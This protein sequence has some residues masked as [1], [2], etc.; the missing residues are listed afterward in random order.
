MPTEY[1]FKHWAK[2][3]DIYGPISSVTVLGQPIVLLNSLE[4]CVDL[5]DKRSSVYSGRP[6][7]HFAGT[8]IKWDL[9]MI[10]SPYG[11]RFRAMRKLVARQIGS[12]AAVAKPAIRA[13]QEREIRHFLARVCEQPDDLLHELR[14]TTAAVFMRL[15]HGYIISKDAN[16]PD[17]LLK[18]IDTAAEE[19]YVATRPGAW[20]VDTF[21]FLRHIPDWFPGAGFKHVAKEFL[22]TN[23]EQVEIPLAYVKSEIR[24]K[25]APSS[26]TADA[27]EGGQFDDSVIMCAAGSLFAGGTDTVVATMGTFILLM[28]RHPEIQQK[29]QAELDAL[30]GGRRL[31]TLD[32]KENLPYLTAVHK[33]VLRW[34]IIGPMGI[35]HST[36]ADDYYKGYFIPKGTIV[37]SNLW[38][39]SQDTAH[40]AEP[41]IFNPE[42]FLGPTPELDPHKYAFGFGR[43]MC[44]GMDLSDANVFLFMAL[45]LSVLEFGKGKGEVEG[46]PEPL[47]HSGTV[48]HPKPYKYSV[49]PRSEEAVRLIQAANDEIPP[50]ESDAPKVK[51]I[52]VP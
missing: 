11:E 22:K 19:F 14:L 50:R 4:G 9:Q 31:P 10:L 13:A 40:H 26:F 52:L 6:T 47:F 7:M 43:R 18:L 1:E 32:D 36:T 46:G 33:E 24:A 25:R 44:P 30:L 45:V 21:P 49:K 27:L 37:F 20:A 48:S 8:M 5:L 51:G 3:K 41:T 16:K 39:I 38:A 29:A 23:L 34:H 2:H 42:R 17:P 15:S 28:I 12:K 35:P